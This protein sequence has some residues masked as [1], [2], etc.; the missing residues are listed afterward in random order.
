MSRKRDIPDRVRMESAFVQARPSRAGRAI[1]VSPGA[2]YA[3]RLADPKIQQRFN[4]ALKRWT[5]R[6]D[7]MI[8]A[9]RASERL[10][11]KDFAIRINARG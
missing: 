2:R 10:T 5:D 11:D 6:T 4:K 9:V 1:S 3:D 8:E 7:P